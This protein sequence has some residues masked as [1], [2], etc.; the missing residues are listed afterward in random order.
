[1]NY[2]EKDVASWSLDTIMKK[3]IT[4]Y[5]KSLFYEE[6]LKEINIELFGDIINAGSK[7]VKFRFLQGFSHK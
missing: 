3:I 4:L 6:N 7:P 2:D 1:M 5:V